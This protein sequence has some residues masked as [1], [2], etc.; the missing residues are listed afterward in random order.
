LPAYNK[1][2][3]KLNNFNESET[4]L[5]YIKEAYPFKGYFENSKVFNN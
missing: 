4:L 3:A 2:S 1:F 5:E